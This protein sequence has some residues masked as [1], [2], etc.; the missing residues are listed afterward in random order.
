MDQEPK[1]LSTLYFG[2][3]QI[4]PKVNFT[5]GNRINIKN[6]KIM[7]FIHLLPIQNKAAESLGHMN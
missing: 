2:Q 6:M 3:N 5:I 7:V 1:L 4:I